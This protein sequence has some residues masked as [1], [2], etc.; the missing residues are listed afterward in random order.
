M[1]AA[2]I[3]IGVS[4]GRPAADGEWDLCPFCFPLFL[5]SPYCV[6]AKIPA[7]L[8]ACD[9]EDFRVFFNVCACFPFV[10]MVCFPA[11]LSVCVCGRQRSDRVGIDT[12]GK[13]Y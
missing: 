6:L 4:S 13:P 5:L 3:I 12:M 11:R 8:E 2:V 7:L 10:R 1:G 9:F